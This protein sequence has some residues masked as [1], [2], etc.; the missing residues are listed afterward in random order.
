MSKIKNKIKFGIAV[1][2]VLCFVILSVWLCLTKE[3]HYIYADQA[4]VVAS[5]FDD[6]TVLIDMDSRFDSATAEDVKRLINDSNIIA[7]ENLT[8]SSDCNIFK[9]EYDFDDKNA[10]LQ[11]IDE[12]KD[13][14]GVISAS[15][16]YII[17][18]A[19][20]EA[21]DAYYSQQWGLTGE[22]GIDIQGAWRFTRGS[23][24]IRVGVIDTG[25]AR[26][27]DLNENLV[28]GWNVV[29]NN[30]NTDDILGHGT[31]VA[32]II[33]AASNNIGITGVCPNVQLV[34]I[35][36]A[37]TK[38]FDISYAIKGI[39]YARGLWGT[40]NQIDIINFSIGGY[41]QDDNNL[42]YKTIDAYPGLLVGSASNYFSDYY[43]G[44]DI[45]TYPI[46]PGSYN[47]DNM[48]VVGAMTEDG[49][50]RIDSNYG[51][52]TVDLF[53]PGEDILSTYPN[54]LCAQGLGICEDGYS[55]HYEDGYH[56][57]GG[58]SMATPFVTGVAALMLSVDETLT[59]TQIKN[60]ICNTVDYSYKIEDY[61][62]TGGRLNAYRAVK[63][64]VGNYKYEETDSG[65]KI[66]GLYEDLSGEI[67]IPAKIKNKSVI[68]MGNEVFYNQSNITK[69]T[70]PASVESVGYGAFRNC[71]K[72]KE[73]RVE[74][75]GKLSSVGDRA[76]DGCTSLEKVVL[77][78]TECAVSISNNT[79]ANNAPNLQ[80]YV[81]NCLLSS[82]KQK[83]GWRDMSARLVD[84]YIDGAGIYYYNSVYLDND[85]YISFYTCF[86][87]DDNPAYE[88]GYGKLT[89]FLDCFIVKINWDRLPIE[90]IVDCSI[91]IGNVTRY[92]END[93][94][95]PLYDKDNNLV[96]ICY[97]DENDCLII[98]LYNVEIYENDKFYLYPDENMSGDIVEFTDEYVGIDIMYRS[99]I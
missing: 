97:I 44:L 56:L 36:V 75:G 84:F 43:Y 91:Y 71:T 16:N 21:S 4:E 64:A 88:E 18:L 35:K 68:A 40:A 77:G 13:K 26:H 1:A 51:R 33:G 74:L 70:I 20:S 24:N 9:I 31:H 81:Y 8:E 27:E 69:V 55:I 65:I 67:T 93:Y 19:S 73:V 11:K 94:N 90:N 6:S 10:V 12:L 5:E 45:D 72:L 85:G 62:I 17:S 28:V 95:Y 49:M 86:P 48:I 52:Y 46:Y 42:L 79:F 41:N 82:Y 87:D 29:D 38:N 23:K 25:I 54:A 34:P 32:G 53:A 37:N 3:K 15:P 63:K 80:V 47:L 98:P 57:K 96:A 14:P 66:V 60:M 61:C 99:Y 78:N 76:F 22:N 30:E 89:Y 59:A 39:D 58:T 92:T 50:K 83:I 2:L 7:V